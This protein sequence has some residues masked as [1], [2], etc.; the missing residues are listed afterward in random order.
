MDPLSVLLDS[1]HASS[2]LAI[3]FR[4]SAPFSLS[5]LGVQGIPFRVAEG[6]PY[7]LKVGQEDWI[8]VEPGDL[9]LLPHGDGHVFAS[10]RSLK[11]VTVG[12]A[13]SA[14]GLE[15]WLEPGAERADPRVIRHGGDGE[16]TT[17]V[18][19]I[20]VFRESARLPLISALPPTIHIRATGAPVLARLSG[21]LQALL[22]EAKEAAPGWS[23]SISRLAEVIFVQALRAHFSNAHVDSSALYRAL[24]D[25][26]IGKALILMHRD[27]KTN[28]TVDTL[29]R[30]V[31]MSRTRFAAR[32][33]AL[34]GQ[35]P[36]TYL[37]Q[38]RLLNASEQLSRGMSV[39]K[40]CEASGYESEKAFSRAFRNWSGTSPARYRSSVRGKS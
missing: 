31:G 37:H 22:D 30:I 4:L 6:H 32:F 25:P 35:P 1:M 28:W 40:A 36:I 14:L 19:G 26:K 18:G 2:A 21:A 3:C 23:I 9:I 13:F 27:L 39:A 38:T 5:K 33:S 29:S 24:A 34:L 17:I 8:R 7:W 10:D 20:L 11:P 15:E 16:L 12:D